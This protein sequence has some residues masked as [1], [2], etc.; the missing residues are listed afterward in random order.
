MV[1]KRHL[2]EQLAIASFV[3]SVFEKRHTED[4]EKYVALLQKYNEVV[5]DRDK[6]ESIARNLDRMRLEKINDR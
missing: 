4:H 2:K 5:K 1:T 3:V 6:W